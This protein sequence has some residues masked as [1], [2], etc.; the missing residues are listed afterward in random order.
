[1]GYEKETTSQTQSAK[2][3]PNT[4]WWNHHTLYKH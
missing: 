4:Y 2:E 1:M 3:P